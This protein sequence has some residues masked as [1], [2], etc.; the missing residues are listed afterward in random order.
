MD[1]SQ[2]TFIA[3]ALAFAAT[4]AATLYTIRHMRRQGIVGQD[5]H[6]PSKP[7]V[8]EMG[9]IAI[10]QA[11]PL[12]LIAAA[13]LY[14]LSNPS[15]SLT[16]VIA[17][18]GVFEIASFVGVV[19][20]LQKLSH[21]IKP[22]LLLLAALP[23]ILLRPGL[24]IIRL[25]YL[26]IDFY[27]LFGSDLSLLF[28]LML[29]PLGITGAAN[30]SNMLAGF[31]GLSSG[32]SFIASVALAA[33]GYLTNQHSVVLIFTAMA[34]AQL[35]FWW[36]NRY[37][38]RIF[39]GDTGTLSFGALLAAGIVV[40]NIEF[41]GLLVLLPQLF[42][43]SI[44]LLSVGRFFE[45][46]EFRKEKFSAFKI[47]KDGRIWFTRLERPIT[48]CKILLYRQPQT[49]NALVSKVYVLGILSSLAALA[50]LSTWI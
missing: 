30:V 4:Y 49:E 15:F 26:T 5:G 16:P 38:A 17:A 1:F 7:E 14:K 20:D 25:P 43:A 45:E 35:A 9:G 46:K 6:K 34:G 3:F 10:L 47:E 50:V 44:S 40:G 37:P 39:P 27:N 12:V 19:D 36:F 2:I 33:A 29:V 42:N 48:L 32:L 11:Y 28:W 23:L 18:L 31:N 21:R 8:P 22:L 13:L 41:I 24:P